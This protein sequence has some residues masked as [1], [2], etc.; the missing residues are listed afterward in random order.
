MIEK[1]LR[2]ITAYKRRLVKKLKRRSPTERMRARQYY[3]SHK[4]KIRLQ[5]RR[6]AK[7]NKLFMKS[8][9]MFKRTKPSWMHK[10]KAP[11]APKMRIHKPKKSPFKKFQKPRKVYVPKRI[12]HK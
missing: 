12:K 11:K 5:R 8:R 6:Y 4:T 7:R 2:V 10:R 9:K 1:V 3:R